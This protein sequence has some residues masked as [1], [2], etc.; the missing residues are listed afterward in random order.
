KM[1]V[2]HWTCIPSL[3]TTFRVFDP[4][5]LPTS[6]PRRNELPGDLKTPADASKWAVKVLGDIH[7]STATDA[8]KTKHDA[9][10]GIGLSALLQSC[11]SSNTCTS[12]V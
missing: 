10:A 9:K 8:D 11:D 4:P 12:N 5:A 6:S 7:V 1:I 3:D 2:L